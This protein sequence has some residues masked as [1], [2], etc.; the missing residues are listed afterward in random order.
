MQLGFLCGRWPFLCLVGSHVPSA[1]IVDMW[2]RSQKDLEMAVEGT[3]KENLLLTSRCEELHLQNPEMGKVTN[4]F[5]G[6]H[7]PRGIWRRL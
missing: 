1:C 4:G 6:D 2:Q 5:E 3:Q 7:M